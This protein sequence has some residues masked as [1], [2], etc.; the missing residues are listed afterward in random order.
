MKFHTFRKTFTKWMNYNAQYANRDIVKWS[1]VM[2]VQLIFCYDSKIGLHAHYQ[3]FI[4]GCVC[5]AYNIALV[6]TIKMIWSKRGPV[7]DLLSSLKVKEVSSKPSLGWQRN[8]EL[9]CYSFSL[10]LHSSMTQIILAFLAFPMKFTLVIL[11]GS[12]KMYWKILWNQRQLL[13]NT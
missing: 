1:F 4:S 3:L 8:R 2:I 9:W 6:V 10:C 13:R 11:E 5:M 7:I 12:N